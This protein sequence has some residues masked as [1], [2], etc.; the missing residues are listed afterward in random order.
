MLKS[1]VARDLRLICMEN[2]PGAPLL[3]LRIYG[4][5]SPLESGKS[6]SHFLAHR[7][8][9]SVPESHIPED[10][11]TCTVLGG[12]RKAGESRADTT[13]GMALSTQLRKEA[14]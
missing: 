9:F 2:V 13:W 3:L 1:V 14:S 11:S 8:D 4:L 7:R 6:K 5:K 12:R 10:W